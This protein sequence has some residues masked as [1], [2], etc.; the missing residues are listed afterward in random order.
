MLKRLQTTRY[1]SPLREGGSLPALAEANDGQLYVV[2][3]LGAGQGRKALIAE[4]LGGEIART[5]GLNVPELALIELDA[6]FGKTEG[7]PEIQDLLRAS[8]GLNVG[9][10]FLPSALMFDPLAEHQVNSQLASK[11]VWLDALT[12][13]VDR[14]IKNPNLLDWRGELWLIDHGAAFYFHHNWSG[15]YLARSRNPFA[16]LKDH[17]LLPFAQELDAVDKELAA[18]LTPER[19]RSIVARIPAEWLASEPAFETP[20]DA[21]RAYL[22]FLTQRLRAPREFFHKA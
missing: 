6:A 7:D 4:V 15:G 8:A 9:M 18:Q 19:L 3:F 16:P 22:E 20:D 2:K 12:L 5:L 11:I 21:R 17:V 14:T 10:A 13:N 1:I